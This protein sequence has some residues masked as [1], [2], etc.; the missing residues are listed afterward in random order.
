MTYRVFAGGVPD[1]YRASTGVI[2]QLSCNDYRIE[3]WF[4]GLMQGYGLAV[5][6]MLL[7]Y[8]CTI[9]L[10]FGLH[11]GN[12]QHEDYATTTKNALW[13]SNDDT[14]IT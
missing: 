13:S 10:K 6:L 8:G 5:V 2:M 3:I 11:S 9:I 1:Y 14:Q 7:F 12:H 4:T